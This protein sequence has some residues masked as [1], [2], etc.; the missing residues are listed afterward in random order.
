M[1]QRSVRGY[2]PVK[3]VIDVVL[4]LVGMVVLAPLF[5]VLAWKVRRE[6][7]SPVLFTQPRPG[8][9]AEVF[10]LRKFRTMTDERD[11]DGALLPDE[12]RLT[13]FGQ[14]LRAS[15]LDELPELLNVLRGEMSLVGPRPLLVEYLPHYAPTQRRRHEVRPG[16]TGWAQVNGR[17]DM[18]WDDKLALDVWYVDHRSLLVDIRILLTTLRVTLRRQGVTREGHVTTTRFDEEQR[19]RD[20]GDVA[21]G[22]LPPGC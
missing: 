2:D 6:L 14:W 3:R 22:D 15:S 9:E 10:L 7:G 13:P 20:D 12:R 16:I 1:A 8:R 4:A 19:G 21:T 5:V 11:A 18:T 17:N